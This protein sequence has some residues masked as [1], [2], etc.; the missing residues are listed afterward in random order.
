MIRV[1]VAAG[2][3][4]PTAMRSLVEAEFERFGLQVASGRVHTQL[5]AIVYV[6]FYGMQ[7]G[8]VACHSK[9]DQNL[10]NEVLGELLKQKLAHY[11]YTYDFK[12]RAEGATPMVEV[13]VPLTVRPE[14]FPAWAEAI[15]AGV[16]QF[17]LKLQ[18]HA[19]K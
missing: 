16:R 19:Y 3:P 9:S 17:L 11:A 15:V 8:R 10:C 4:Y 18:Q 7:G 1:L 2:N 14:D 12:S 13:R 6:A 5:A